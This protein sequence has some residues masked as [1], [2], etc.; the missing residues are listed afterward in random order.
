MVAVVAAYGQT[1]E[2]LNPCGKCRQVLFDLNPSIDCVVRT[3]NGYVAVP[4]RELLPYAYDWQGIES[5]P[6]RL[7]MWE[8]YEEKIRSGVKRQTIRIDDP[9]RAGPAEVVFEK[10]TGEVTTISVV[11]TEVRTVKRSDLV[12]L[13]AQRDGFATLAELHSALDRHYPGLADDNTVDLVEFEISNDQ[14]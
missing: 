13:D 1:A 6:Q 5:S 14:I 10:T 3:A 4:V 8:G 12:E 2:V 7:Y 9:F 11:I